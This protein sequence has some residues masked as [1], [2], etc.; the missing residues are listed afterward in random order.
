MNLRTKN[1]IQ[2]VLEGFSRYKRYMLK[3]LVYCYIQTDDLDMLDTIDEMFLYE[4]RW[5]FFDKHTDSE[6]LYETHH[7]EEFVG[8]LYDIFN[9]GGK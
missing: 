5:E 1:E 9:Y 8:I 4:H 6:L 3:A 7:L 2:Q